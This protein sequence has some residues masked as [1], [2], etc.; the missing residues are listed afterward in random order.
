[1]CAKLAQTQFLVNIVS[2]LCKYPA[3]TCFYEKQ[4]YFLQ[5]FHQDLNENLVGRHQVAQEYLVGVLEAKLVQIMSILSDKLP[6]LQ[7]DAII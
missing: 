1:M 7:R 4:T 5:R 6:N 2:D 3:Q